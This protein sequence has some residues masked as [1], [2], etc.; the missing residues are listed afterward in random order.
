MSKIS[1]FFKKYDLGFENF[2]ILNYFLSVFFC[3]KV[4]LVPS[5]SDAT[6]ITNGI[7]LFV[8]EFL[9]MH[10]GVFL[11]VFARSKK[12]FLIALLYGLMIYG[13]A[14]SFQNNYYFYL[15]L[16]IVMNR[17]RVGFS[18]NPVFFVRGI[19]MSIAGGLFFLVAGISMAILENWIPQFGLTETYLTQ[20]GFR[21][22]N[23]RTGGML[24]DK[25]QTVMYFWIVYFSLWIWFE[26]YIRDKFKDFEDFD[27]SEVFWSFTKRGF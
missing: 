21:W 11:S 27:V 12:F 25:P 6:F 20:S 17:M 9:M 3:L 10:S 7:Q 4:W 2:Q 5:Q 13:L 8:V 14:K 19:A 15:Y 18:A 24:V 16:L 26:F 22:Q 23:A 1:Q